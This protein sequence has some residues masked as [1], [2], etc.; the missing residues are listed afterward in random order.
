MEFYTNP[1]FIRSY[2]RVRDIVKSINDINQISTCKKLISNFKNYWVSK[3]FPLVIM[4][5]IYMDDLYSF[6][7]AKVKNLNLPKHE[8]LIQQN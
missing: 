8:K 3:G 2:R 7:N 4:D 5:S 6:L 1:E